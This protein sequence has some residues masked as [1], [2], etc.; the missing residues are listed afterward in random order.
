M[1][2]SLRITLSDGEII[3]K[4]PDGVDKSNSSSFDSYLSKKSS[5]VFLYSDL[6][7]EFNLEKNIESVKILDSRT[8]RE[9]SALNNNK[10]LTPVLETVK[11]IDIK[12]LNENYTRNTYIVDSNNPGFIEMRNYLLNNLNNDG[13]N[14]LKNIYK[15]DNAFSSIMNRYVISINS[16]FNEEDSRNIDALR[17]EVIKA[18]TIYKNYRSVCVAR[19]LYENNYKITTEEKIKP[20]PKGLGIQ[21]GQFVEINK[22]NDNYKNMYTNDLGEEREEFLDSDEIDESYGTR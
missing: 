4:V 8:G 3:C 16:N 14:F 22:D 10:Y 2:Y 9:Y 17:D 1:A 19:Y 15:N 11:K 7:K 20:Q 5:N 12:L 21:F 6:K 18:L 13:A